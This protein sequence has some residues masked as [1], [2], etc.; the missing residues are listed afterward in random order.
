MVCLGWKGLGVRSRDHFLRLLRGLPEEEIGT[1]RRAEHRDNHGKVGGRELDLG[2]EHAGQN[3]G[4]RHMNDENDADIG[5]ERIR[6]ITGYLVGTL[7]RFNNGKRAEEADRIKHS[8][9]ST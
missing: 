4:P 8:C 1:D 7:D 9:S 5:F 6:R 2:H 3:L